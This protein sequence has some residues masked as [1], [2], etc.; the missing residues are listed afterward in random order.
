MS[1]RGDRLA[2]AAIVAGSAIAFLSLRVP[3]PLVI[4][5]ATALA[6]VLLALRGDRPVAVPQLLTLALAVTIVA[7][8]ADTALAL[9][10]DWQAGRSLSEGASLAFVQ[11]QLRGFERLRAPCR[12]LALFSSLALLIGAIVTRAST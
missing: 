5:L 3:L 7:M 8:I 10:A 6:G 2:I 1:P 11:A 12:P 4:G 9:Y